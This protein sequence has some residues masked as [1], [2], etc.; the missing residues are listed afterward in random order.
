MYILPLFMY[1]YHYQSIHPSARETLGLFIQPVVLLMRARKIVKMFHWRTKVR[2]ADRNFRRLIIQ[3]SSLT[4][5]ASMF[6]CRWHWSGDF[7]SNRPLSELFGC[8]RHCSKVLEDV[9][10]KCESECSITPGVVLLQ[11]AFWRPLI[12]IHVF[13]FEDIRH[14]YNYG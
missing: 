12:E 7:R 14:M 3:T 1:I 2:S 5:Q 10:Q 8:R 6:S 9:I 11:R 13:F 4:G